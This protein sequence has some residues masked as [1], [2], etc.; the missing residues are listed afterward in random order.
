ML[1]FFELVL[2]M[3]G[4][5]NLPVHYHALYAIQKVCFIVTLVSLWRS[6]RFAA[7]V[8]LLA[9]LAGFCVKNFRALDDHILTTSQLIV[10][11]IN[12]LSSTA[13]ASLPPDIYLYW[14]Q[15]FCCRHSNAAEAPP[16]D[17]LILAL[18]ARN[19]SSTT[20]TAVDLQLR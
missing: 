5:H 11:A 18:G 13:P 20:R 7:R 9:S 1:A 17:A 3:I 16:D 8:T 12:P 15:S 10:Y 2:V 19:R 14:L 4:P 6:F